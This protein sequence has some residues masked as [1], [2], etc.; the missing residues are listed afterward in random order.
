MTKIKHPLVSTSIF[1]IGVLLLTSSIQLFSNT[2]NAEPPACDNGTLKPSPSSTTLP[3]ILL[4]GY[5]EISLMWKNW[6]NRLQNEF[7]FCTVSFHPDDVCGTAAHDATEIGQIIQKVKSMT[8]QNQVNIV[9]HSKGG[10]DARLYLSNSGTHDVA[11]LIMIGTPNKGSPF[12]DYQELYYLDPYCPALHDLTTHSSVIKIPDNP[13]TRYYT[14]AGV[15]L[16]YLYAP[17]GSIGEPNDGLVGVTSAQSHYNS[18]GLSPH[19]HLQLLDDYEYGL[20][21]DILSGKH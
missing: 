2:G 21:H 8:H 19:C 10:L 16:P 4:H 1:T 17:W 13:N 12:A 6:E 14:I 18:I 11:N 20:A 9:A 3:V 5:K 7:Q 15:C